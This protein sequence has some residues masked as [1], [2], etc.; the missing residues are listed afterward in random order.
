MNFIHVSDVHSNRERLESVRKVFNCIYETVK[1]HNVD[2]VLFAGD[3]WDSTITNTKAS[4]FTE[5]VEMVHALRQMCQVVFIYGT[6][7]HEPKGALDVFSSIGCTVIDTPTRFT[8]STEK[9]SVDIL[10]I[11]EPRRGDYAGITTEE[12]NSLI[13]KS[14]I[15][16]AEHRKKDNP[17][18]VA[19]HGEVAGSQYQNGMEVKSRIQFPVNLLKDMHADYYALG[20]IHLPQEVFKNAFYPGSPAP[21]DF[22]E[23]HEG[24]IHLVE[25]GEQ[26]IVTP[27]KTN[28]PLFITI[29]LD[30]TSVKKF[31]PEPYSGNNLRVIVNNGTDNDSP[32]TIISTLKNK[33]NLLSCKVIVNRDVKNTIRSSNIAK[34]ITSLGKYEEYCKIANH[35]IDEYERDFLRSIDE[36]KMLLEHHPSKTFELQSI[37]LKGSIGIK[38]GSGKEDI[39]IDFTNYKQGVVAMVGD[40]GRGKTTIIENCHP[41]PKMLTRKG[42]LKEHF[43]LK[44][45]HRHLVYKSSDGTY[46]RI[47]MNIDAQSKHGSTTYF[48]QTSKDGIKWNP[49]VDTDGSL[50]AYKQFVDKT[51]GPIDLFIRTSFFTKKETKGTPDLTTAT[52]GEKIDFFSNLAG[53]DWLSEVSD[54]AKE[55]AVE[56]K[57]DADKIGMKIEDINFAKEELDECISVVEELEEEI[58]SL[59]DDS[60]TI[61]KQIKTLEAYEADRKEKELLSQNAFELKMQIEENLK[62]L[63]VEMAEYNERLEIY[64]AVSKHKKELS[65]ITELYKENEGLDELLSATKD[66]VLLLSNHIDNLKDQLSF[67][68]Q[69]HNQMKLLVA[70]LENDIAIHKAQSHTYDEHCPVCGSQLSPDKAAELN[71]VAHNHESEAIELEMKKGLLEERMVDILL[72][73]EASSKKIDELTEQKSIVEVELNKLTA[74]VDSINAEL[75]SIE[76]MLSKS[77]SVPSYIMYQNQD[78]TFDINKMEQLKTREAEL[79]TKL[80]QIQSIEI[81][82]SKQAEL[83]ECLNERDSIKS[84]IASAKGEIKATKSRITKLEKLISSV[85]ELKAELRELLEKLKA[86]NHIQNAFSKTGI[87]LMELESAMPEIAEMAN[88]ILEKSYGDRFT[89]SFET[90]RQ[91]NKKTV[92]DLNIVVYDSQQGMSKY[93]DMVCSGEEV[94]IKQALF[95]AF[96]I[97]R[98]NRTGFSFATRF[99]DES[100]SSL[101]TGSRVKYLSMI[102]AAHKLTGASLSILITHSQ[103][104]KDIAEQIIEV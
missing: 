35:N 80:S 22:G 55:A 18:I 46:L 5:Y 51:F 38:C 104:I 74:K 102:E 100:D 52:K 17:F 95:Y 14:Y 37:S 8:L 76:D 82:P 64:N 103:E 28:A 21:V 34:K 96:S 27:I 66:S 73:I 75:K 42:T 23:Q 7:R 16:L 29:E 101:D 40:N 41:Y 47:L 32:H 13:L 71:L 39:Q 93:L 92:D 86:Y 30:S 72:S 88:G 56:T 85:D 15:K 49:C 94:W 90:I 59:Q 99:I 79:T 97:V 48:A 33:A 91:G 6:P 77:C 53:N 2:F 60:T 50:D 36:N 44:D 62:S 69:Q 12:T 89:I 87:P 68:Q 19:F 20:H 24:C 45:S 81:P 98:M 26:T 31:N 11:P 65:R 70:N 83:N 54:L 43:F 61:E 78:M 58:S 1:K 25:L 84:S 67:D 57:K 4:G 9:E 63:A 3:F 10:A